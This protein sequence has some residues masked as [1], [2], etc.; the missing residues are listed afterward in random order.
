MDDIL[1]IY[2]SKFERIFAGEDP[3]SIFNRRDIDENGNMIKVPVDKEFL[4]RTAR[5]IFGSSS[6][7]VI[8][9]VEELT[10]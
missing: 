4:L 6:E 3:N 7:E 2:K 1:E 5:A 10:F 8:K 9:K